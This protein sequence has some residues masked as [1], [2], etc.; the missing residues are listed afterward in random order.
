MNKY[1]LLSILVLPSTLT[2]FISIP[3]L[4]LSHSNI[5]K[6]NSYK[7]GLIIMNAQN[8]SKSS[9]IIK[10]KFNNIDDELRDYDDKLLKI[11]VLFLILI[12]IFTIETINN[13]DFH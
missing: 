13:F 6:Y 2:S 1:L 10:V 11:N 3:N 7:N 9:K 8:K 12:Y 4:S 5:N